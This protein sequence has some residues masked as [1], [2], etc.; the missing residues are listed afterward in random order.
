M[1]A[2]LILVISQAVIG[3][4]DEEVLKVSAR[5]SYLEAYQ[6]SKS[7]LKKTAEKKNDRFYPVYPG[8]ENNYNPPNGPLASQYGP[9]VSQYGPPSPQYG[10]PSPQYG[11]PSPQYGPPQYGPPQYGPPPYGGFAEPQYGPPSQN[12]QVFYGVPHAMVNIWDKILEKIKWKLDLFTF[13]KILLKLVIFKKIV[14]L[15]AILCLLLFIPKLKHKKLFLGGASEDDRGLERSSAD[16]RLRDM[17]VFVN[18]A[19]DQFRTSTKARSL[20]SCDTKYCESRTIL[21]KV[22]K[23]SYEKLAQLYMNETQD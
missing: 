4:A 11:P 3:L 23:M 5:D 19:I 13:G 22:E 14:S 6:D 9:P 10:P 15:I 17:A 12:L 2:L 18:E 16:D 8:P 1:Q 20:P 7:A 21:R